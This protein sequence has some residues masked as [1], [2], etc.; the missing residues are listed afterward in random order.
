MTNLNSVEP[1]FD[2]LGIEDTILQTLK[3]NKF[4]NPTPIQNQCIPEAIDGK[5]IV[6]IAQTGTGKTLA[7]VLPTIQKILKEKKQGLI[8][9]PTRELA[10]QA[11]EMFCKIGKPLGL[12]TALLIGG[13]PIY[14]QV[15]DI[16]RNPDVIIATPGRLIDHLNRKNLSFNKINLVVLD[17]ADHMFDIGFLPDVK[18]ILS[19]TPKN[20][21]TLLFSATMP[22]SIM[23]VVSE[24][25]KIPIHI[26]I[27]PSGTVATGVEQELFI[28]RRSEKMPLLKKIIADDDG[29]ILLFLRTKNTVRKITQDIKYMDYTVAEVHSDRSLPQRRR[30]LEGFK[31]GKYRILVATD[32][33]AR[34]IDV[35][36]IS[37]VINYDLPQNSEDYVHRIGRTGRAGSKGKA[38][39]FATPDQKNIVD[40]IEKLTKESISVKKSTSSEVKSAEF[41]K[42]KKPYYK[43]SR[44]FS[45]NNFKGRKQDKKYKSFHKKRK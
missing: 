31:N 18:K 34:G 16:K 20:R 19:L 2:N 23:Q 37:V 35:S 30:S 10:I 39:S 38:I 32:I 15:R 40:Q 8:I 28:V 24:F 26:E 25:M 29:K 21:Q 3:N 22:K 6:G 4:I 1:K 43:K 13:D 9:A 42:N 33:A 14:H 44:N 41:E 12:K 17:E 36:D 7:F 45:K 27:A 11:N 5:D